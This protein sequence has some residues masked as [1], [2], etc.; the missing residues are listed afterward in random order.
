VQSCGCLQRELTAERFRDPTIKP[1]QQYGR[2]MVIDEA[3]SSSGHMMWWSMCSCPEANEIM[4]RGSD[5]KRG[6]TTSCGCFKRE[7]VPENAKGCSWRDFTCA[8][9]TVIRLQ[10]SYELAVA[11]LLDDNGVSFVAHPL[12]GIPWVDERGGKPSLFC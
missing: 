4:V 8:N 5:L 9:G 6:W 3:G 10:G 12:P 2:L 11:R 1:G 7:Q